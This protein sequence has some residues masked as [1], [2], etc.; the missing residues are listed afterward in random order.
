MWGFGATGEV[1]GTGHVKLSSATRVSVG[2][3]TAVISAFGNGDMR[4]TSEKH[5]PYW[6]EER[7]FASKKLSPS[8]SPRVWC[9]A[10]PQADV[11]HWSV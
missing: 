5:G 4:S 2:S 11:A 8:A 1:A 7:G 9:H 3:S 10:V 6:L